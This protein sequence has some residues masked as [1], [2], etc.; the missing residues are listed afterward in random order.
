M[1]GR[2]PNQMRPLLSE[3]AVLSR[4]DGSA[5]WA[6]EGSAVLAAVHGPHQA[7]QRREDAEKAV[8]EVL[9]KP[10]NGMAGPAE[11]E[12]E[13]MLRQLL[14]QVLLTAHHPRTLIL[15][16][17]QVLQADGSLLAVAIN[18]VC[19]AL[20]DAGLPMRSMF[21]GVCCAFGADGTLV[22]DPDA[23][24]EQAAASVVTAAFPCSHTLQQ[25]QGSSGATPTLVLPEASL[26]LSCRG[27]LGLPQLASGLEAC[28]R[29]CQGV[30]KF[31][32]LALT[33][34]FK[35]DSTAQQLQRP[36]NPPEMQ[37]VHIARGCHCIGGAPCALQRPGPLRAWLAWRASVT[38]AVPGD[39][40]RLAAMRAAAGGGMCT[41]PAGQLASC[42]APAGPHASEQLLAASS[43]AAAGSWRELR[44]LLCQGGGSL[45]G[46]QL[47]VQ[48]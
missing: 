6:Q 14:E 13:E 41:S 17:V 15:V 36:P 43:A 21:A 47:A 18:A 42:T 32:A 12:A 39:A 16:V 48:A 9:F 20:A 38:A 35:F 24:E 1:K 46:R 25:Q 11:R 22:I 40:R 44:Q 7:G 34:S 33:N 10:R 31:V 30:A 8:V 19:A 28:R 4:A 45:I 29:G 3:R 37:A 26:L 2:L 5:K 27:R 23:A